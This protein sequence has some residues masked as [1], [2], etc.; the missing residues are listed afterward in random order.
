[1]IELEHYHFAILMAM[2]F[3]HRLSVDSKNYLGQIVGNRIFIE[4]Q[5]KKFFVTKES[6]GEQTS[7]KL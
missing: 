2:W 3:R 5:E 4:R 7:T 6:F 1:M